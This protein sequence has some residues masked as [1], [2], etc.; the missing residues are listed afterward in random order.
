MELYAVFANSTLSCFAKLMCL[1]FVDILVGP[2][3]NLHG[4]IVYC[5]RLKLQSLLIAEPHNFGIFRA[6]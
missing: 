4:T 5:R 1:M 6:L 2:A 3:I